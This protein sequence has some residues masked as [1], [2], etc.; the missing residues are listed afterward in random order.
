[1]DQSDS[2]VD[3]IDQSGEGAIKLSNQVRGNKID[4]SGEG[5]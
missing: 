1:M 2:R 3:K 5:E 4:Q